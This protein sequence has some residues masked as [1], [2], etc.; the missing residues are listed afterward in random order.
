[1]SGASFEI[2][3]DL[4][5]DSVFEM[6]SASS[7]FNQNSEFFRLSFQLIC[8]CWSSKVGAARDGPD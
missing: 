4:S 5:V 7:E 2:E 3:F 1:M 6:N 8:Y